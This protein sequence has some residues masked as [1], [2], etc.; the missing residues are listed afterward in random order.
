VP[1]SLEQFKG[2]SRETYRR[3]GEGRAHVGVSAYRRVRQAKRYH[4][5]RAGVQSYRVTHAGTPIRRHAS[6]PPYSPLSGRESQDSM[7]RN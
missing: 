4:A 5:R 2:V 7:L 1:C 3:K 6:A